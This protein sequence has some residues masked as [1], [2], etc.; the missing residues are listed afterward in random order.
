MGKETKAGKFS[1]L[2]PVDGGGQF[3]EILLNGV[4]FLSAS[5]ELVVVGPERG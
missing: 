2:L 3:P 4:R 5:N 1:A